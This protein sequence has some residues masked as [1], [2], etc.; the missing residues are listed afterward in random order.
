MPEIRPLMLGKATESTAIA[1]YLL[2]VG[3]HVHTYGHLDGEKC[4]GG[5][6]E[7]AL[8]QRQ[9]SKAIEKWQA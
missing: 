6:S 4:L 1:Q 8:W 5:D 2:S 7:C 9:L 3:R